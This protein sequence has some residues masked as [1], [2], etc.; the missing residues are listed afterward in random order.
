[1]TTKQTVC[2]I[3]FILIN[4]TEFP[5][6]CSVHLINNGI[7]IHDK[8]VMVEF[9]VVDGGSAE[10]SDSVARCTINGYLKPCKL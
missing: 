6:Q 7:T 8:R 9:A 1:M 4:F 2:C 10:G 3:M 5:E